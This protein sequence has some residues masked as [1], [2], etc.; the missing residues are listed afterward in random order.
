MRLLILAVLFFTT[1]VYAD[2]FKLKLVNDEYIDYNQSDWVIAAR[3]N[4]YELFAYKGIVGS[5]DNTVETHSLVEF[6]P[7][8]GSIINP[9]PTPIKRIYTY[10][11][12]ECNNGIFHLMNSWYVDKDHK[13][14]YNQVYD[15][16]TYKV[17]VS[18]K[19]TPRNDLYQLVCNKQ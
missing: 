1:N 13:I 12:M 8:E 18:S 6:Y 17:E 16:G 3:T 7:P 2:D 19:N 5:T 11:I 15:F 10:G 9:I 14:V 4:M